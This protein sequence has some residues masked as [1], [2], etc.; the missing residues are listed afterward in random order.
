[1]DKQNGW[2]EYSRLVLN[3]LETLSTGI[4]GINK[5]IQEIRQ[6][7]VALKTKEDKVE[8]LIS[9][10]KRVDE[11]ASPTQLKEM[12]DELSELQLQKESVDALNGWKQKIDEISSPTQLAKLSS[13][14]SDLK[15]FKVKAITIFAVIQFTMAVAV[16]W[17]KIF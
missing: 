8:E 4:A 13:E 16:A 10:K 9:W 12:K 2:N 15:T 14:V 6:E 11:I 1:M 5:E 17:S 3:E 7:L